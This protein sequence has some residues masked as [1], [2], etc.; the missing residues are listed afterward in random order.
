MKERQKLAPVFPVHPTVISC[1]SPKGKDNAHMLEASLWPPPPP[2][3]DVETKGRCY[4]DPSSADKH[5][6]LK[7]CGP[8]HGVVMTRY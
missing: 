7:C 6:Q 4:G 8:I 2:G 5:G 1:L 3:E